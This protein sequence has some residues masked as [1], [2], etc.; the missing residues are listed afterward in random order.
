MFIGKRLKF[1]RNENHITQEQLAVLLNLERS[2]IASFEA[3][4]T[5]PTLKHIEKLC[6]I[7][8]VSLYYF[9]SEDVS[10]NKLQFNV[11]R[12]VFYDRDDCIQYL[13]KHEAINNLNLDKLNDNELIEFANEIQNYIET[14]S[15]KYKKNQ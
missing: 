12:K 11:I 13:S 2:S 6:D 10:N 14:L 4:R 8:N 9:L 3:N 7:F 5:P 1:L 15:Y